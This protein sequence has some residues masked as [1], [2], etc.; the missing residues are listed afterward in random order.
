MAR[1]T[2]WE[3]VAPCWHE[4][5]IRSGM[6]ADPTPQQVAAW[7]ASSRGRAV[8]PEVV[9]AIARRAQGESVSSI[10]AELG[11]S[12]RNLS[13][14]LS[15]GVPALL[16]QWVED[17][18]SW[19]L[20]CEQGR[21]TAELAELYGVPE[22]LITVALD[23]WPDP[24]QAPDAVAAEVL[25]LWRDGADL[26]EIAAELNVPPGRLRRWVQEGSVRLT[27]ARLRTAQL[28]ERFGWSPHMAVLYR[29]SG[30]LPAPDGGR[31]PWWWST[32]IARLERDILTH[33]CDECDAR[34]AS[35]KGLAIHRGRVHRPAAS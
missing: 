18:A 19:K 30:V 5:L 2:L 33:R 7:K 27:P 17:V 35:A 1:Y 31:P 6:P 24:N 8:R 11:M 4:P 12:R 32:T 22:H 28:V 16:E 14:R 15:T 20:G 21:S 25:Q 29:D 13:T 23:G 9:E 3:A 26:D 34:L 10:A